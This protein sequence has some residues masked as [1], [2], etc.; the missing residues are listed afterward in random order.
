M[1]KTEENL[2]AAFEGE[3]Q[4]NRKYLAYAQQAD[5]E[6]Y[7]QIAKLF[8][9]VADA[10]TIHAHTHFRN[11]GGVRSTAEN[12]QAAINGETYEF[13][14]MYPPF[15]EKAEDEGHTAATRGF[16][17]A[18][19]AEKVHGALY[20]KALDDLGS[21]QQYDLYLCSVCGH[22]A[23]KNAPDKCPIC[24]AKASAYKKY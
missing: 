7:K 4:A 16:K 1:S 14:E 3:S 8:R 21:A 5:A 6:G 13:T 2:A 22:V 12:L 23:E 11:N 24:G 19:E 17:L 20:Q 9:V 18:N 10:E 15:I